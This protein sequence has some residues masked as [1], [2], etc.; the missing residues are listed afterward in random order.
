M[1]IALKILALVI[2]IAL[3]MLSCEKSPTPQDSIENPNPPIKADQLKENI[4]PTKPLKIPDTLAVTNIAPT[5]PTLT[6]DS[7]IN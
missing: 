3:T 6:Q 1:K 2:I 5:K 7:I 4:R